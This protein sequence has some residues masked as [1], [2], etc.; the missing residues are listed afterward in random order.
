MA[1]AIEYFRSLIEGEA[2]R[3]GSFLRESSCR[4]ILILIGCVGF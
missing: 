1:E 3:K 4:L 2:N